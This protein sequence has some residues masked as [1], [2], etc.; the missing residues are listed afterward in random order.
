MSYLGPAIL[1]LLGGVT[2]DPAE[3][4][5]ALGEGEQLLVGNRLVHGR[6]CRLMF[7]KIGF[8]DLMAV[9]CCCCDHV[10]GFMSMNV[11]NIDMS[12]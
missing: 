9:T 11:E 10:T 6:H 5:A 4:A 12:D 3:R 2:G 7:Q 8:G 1:A